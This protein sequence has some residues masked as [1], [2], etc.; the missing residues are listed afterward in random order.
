[1]YA[2]PTAGCAMFGSLPCIRDIQLSISI[3]QMSYIIIELLA[4]LL[5]VMSIAEVVWLKFA[6]L[7]PDL[8]VLFEAL[9]THLV[10]LALGSVL[11]H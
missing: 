3:C 1:M 7:A 9:V 5:H 6:F 10:L 11:K 2:R 4:Q 8:C